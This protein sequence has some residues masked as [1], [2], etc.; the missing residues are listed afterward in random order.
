MNRKINNNNPKLN[1]KYVREQKKISQ[2][3][4]AERLNISQGYISEIEK[5]LKSPTVRVLYEIANALEVCPH[6]LLPVTIYCDNNC[7]IRGL[8]YENSDI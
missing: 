3:E 1:L 5:N 6:S 2:K 7:N 4:L 8:N